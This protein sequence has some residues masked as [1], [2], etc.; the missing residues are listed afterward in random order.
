LRALGRIAEATLAAER[1]RQIAERL[2]EPVPLAVA[3]WAR[4]NAAAGGGSYRRSLTLTTRA[5]DEL[6][7]H[8]AA[9]GALMM[10]GMLHLSSAVAELRSRP[11]VAA[12]HLAEAVELAARTGEDHRWW[13]WW[14]PTNVGVWRMGVMVDAGEPGRA[15]EIAAGVQ[16]DAV[17]SADRR[18]TYHLELGRA[19]TDLGGSRDA[20]A[21]RALLTAERLAP[22][23]MRSYTSARETARFLHDRTF[24]AAGG[25][26]LR[27]LCERMGVAG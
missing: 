11:E 4:A 26:A 27:G 18:A 13:M 20:E 2:G 1:C 14:G 12:D 6:H 23:R 25:S 19:L 15:V 3:D 9:D 21:V 10:L 24:R 22:Q 7:N 8:A 17:P 16:P 5:A